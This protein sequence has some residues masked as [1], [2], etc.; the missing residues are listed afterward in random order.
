MYLYILFGLNILDLSNHR[1]T[2]ILLLLMI[3][4]I[5]VKG[6]LSNTEILC[7]TM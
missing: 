4:K 7:S 5:C 1:H 6:I 2:I 3:L